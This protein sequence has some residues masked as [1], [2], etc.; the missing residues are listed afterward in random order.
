MHIPDGVLSVPVVA[1]GAVATAGA[2]ALTLRRV[3][4]A[5]L[6]KVALVTAAFFIAS[7]INISVG[8][9]SVHLV[10]SALIGLVLGW[11]AIPAVFVGLVLQAVFFGFGGITTLGVTTMTIALPG[12]L[13]AR[14]FAPLIARSAAPGRKALWA[15]IAAAASIMTSGVMVVTVL[16]LSDIAYLHSAP[17]VLATYLPLALGEAMVTGFAVAFLARVS[18]EVLR[19]AHPR[20]LRSAQLA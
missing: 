12:I 14:A 15:G 9:T 5:M 13:W 7:L 11:A 8:P 17:L 20:A 4:E 18:P 2:L 16:A 19:A 1:V 3:D 6:P 10:L